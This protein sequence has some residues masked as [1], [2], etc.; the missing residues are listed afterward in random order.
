[1]AAKSIIIAVTMPNQKIAN[2]IGEHLINARL[3]ACYQDLGKIKS[4][5]FWQNKKTKANEI[6]VLLIALKSNFS[7]IEKAIK[8]LHPYEVPQIIAFE[9]SQISKDY[10]SWISFGS[11]K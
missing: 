8:K 2:K 6:L 4:V 11:I 1:M 5:Y 7:R 10:A 3:I 9:A